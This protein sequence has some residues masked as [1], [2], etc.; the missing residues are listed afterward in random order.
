MRLSDSVYW[1]IIDFVHASISL[2]ASRSISY[3]VDDVV[4][5]DVGDHLTDSVYI[6]VNDSVE[7]SVY[8]SS[9]SYINEIIDSV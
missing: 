2:Y 4:R 9:A 7:S 8:L 5:H 6:P 3:F 1:S